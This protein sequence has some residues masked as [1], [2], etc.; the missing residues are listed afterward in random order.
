MASDYRVDPVTDVAH[1]NTLFSM[2]ETPHV[3][4]AW[5]YGE[6]KQAAADWRTRRVAVDAGGWRVRRIVISLRDEPVAVCQ[7]LDKRLAGVTVATRVNRGPLFLGADP[8]EDVVRGV[9]SVLR[10]GAVRGRVPLVLA[11][12]LP[13]SP[14]AYRL[15]SELGYRPRQVSGWISDRV[16]LRLDEEEMQQRLHRDWR[17][18]LR[19]AERAGVEFRVCDSA[20]DLEWLMEHHV[21]HMQQKQFVGMNPA[22]LQALR[23]AAPREDI[24]VT[25]VRLGG[26]PVGGLVTFRFGKA[27]E[28]LIFW[29]GQEARRADAGRYIDWRTALELKQRGCEWLDLGGKRAGATE[30]FKAGLGGV[31]YRLLNEWIAL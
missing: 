10:G 11:P 30:T 24:L 27:A 4:Q 23:D 3:V 18:R 28:G 13:D 25:Q 21:E 8:R 1:W 20:E 12:A 17:W 7:L 29:A 15:L 26:E 2:V 22:F 6:A 5:A 16:D 9:Y 14:E 19:R 31:E